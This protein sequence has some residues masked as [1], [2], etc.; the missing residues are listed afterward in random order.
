M[1]VSLQSQHHTLR[2]GFLTVFYLHIFICFYLHF[3]KSLLR[4]VA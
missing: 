1:Q 4:V 2:P 3:A